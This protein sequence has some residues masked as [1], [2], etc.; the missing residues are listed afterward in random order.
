[1]DAEKIKIGWYW[2]LAGIWGGLALMIGHLYPM[3]APVQLAAFLPLLYLC[4]THRP[5]FRNAFCGGFYMGL[6]YVVPQIFALKMPV[7][8]TAILVSYFTVL[9]VLL[10]FVLAYLFKKPTI[11]DALAVGTSLVIFDFIN[12]TALAMWGLA[13]SIVRPWSSYPMLI[14]F[15]SITGL[16]GIIFAIG[17][18]QAMVLVVI[19]N[20]KDRVKSGLVIMAIILSLGIAD[21][22]NWNMKSVGNIKVAAIGSL[23]RFGNEKINKTKW[24]D[25]QDSYPEFVNEAAQAGARI[26]VSPEIGF[27]F[28]ENNTE[29]I[30]GFV[31]LAKEHDVCLV[32]G[33]ACFGE[34]ENR[35]LFIQPDGQT[36]QYVKT[37]ITPFEPFKN[38][39]G[40]LL[41]IPVDGIKCGAMICQDDNF[42][43][44]C[45]EYGRKQVQVV[46]VPT[47]DWRTVKSTHLQSSTHRAIEQRYAVVRAAMDGISAIISAKGEIDA[48]KDHFE[49]GAGLIVADVP[50]YTG[51]TF[52]SRFGHWPVGASFIYVLVYVVF[53]VMKKEPTKKY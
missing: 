44:L 6:A 11:S 35:L 39:D 30:E 22:L 18:L 3:F 31:G 28:N 43:K 37:Y 20:R 46:A 25:F 50:V 2:R 16:T 36:S 45:R 52:Y 17:F 21:Y 34:N 4:V 29:I 49:E 10:G 8:I 13:Q 27:S 23:N 41:E 47:L 40:E 32:I 51:K 33:Y 53:T 24:K 9:F 19:I 15:T 14:G 1:M 42:A 5:S 12:F 48:S 7:H 26:I 38:G